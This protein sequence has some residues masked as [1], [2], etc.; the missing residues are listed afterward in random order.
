M[1]RGAIPLSASD[2]TI[3]RNVRRLREDRK[4]SQAELS[5]A[6]R[7]R[8]FP[9]TPAAVSKVEMVD[10]GVN[11][12][13]V[14]ASELVAIAEVFGVTLDELVQPYLEGSAALKKAAGHAV[15]YVHALSAAR[16][17]AVAALTAAEAFRRA[18]PH[19][20]ADGGLDSALASPEYTALVDSIRD[21]DLISLYRLTPNPSASKVGEWTTDGVDLNWQASSELANLR[22]E[23]GD[24][25]EVVRHYRETG[26]Y[27]IED[28][29]ID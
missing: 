28:F 9:F 10:G 3:S 5:A 18:H 24:K 25:D 13:R 23:F 12:R 8:G 22:W 4:L 16:E 14:S 2:L 19:L 6:L 26:E 11:Q 29:S 1:V 21:E 20:I 15:D 17:N 7:A 27:L